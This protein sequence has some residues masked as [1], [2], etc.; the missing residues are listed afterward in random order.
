MDSGALGY[1]RVEGGVPFVQVYDPA[2]GSREDLP[3]FGALG[4]TALPFPPEMD[5][6]DSPSGEWAEG[7][8]SYDVD[9][10]KGVVF[11]YRD[12]RGAAI[13]GNLKPGDTAIHTTGPGKKAQLQLKQA[14]LAAVMC[15]DSRDKDM[16]LLM[17]GKDDEVTLTAFGNHITISRDGIVL[18]EK[19]GGAGITITKNYVHIR[20]Q[21][22]LG[23]AAP[24]PAM[25]LMMGPNTPNVPYI[26]PVTGA[27]TTPT[28]TTLLP[29]PGVF[30]CL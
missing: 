16:V 3:M 21:V 5:E 8:V 9:G 1:T 26:I 30:V 23:G 25:A 17:N 24:N 10:F 18:G 14:G 22:L 12:S 13:V 11:G 29:V 20:G 4:V 2:S 27:P 7:L 28:P 15:K 19:S 6:D